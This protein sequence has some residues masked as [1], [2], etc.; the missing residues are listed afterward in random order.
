MNTLIILNLFWDILKIKL[1]NLIK[2]NNESA[3]KKNSYIY[4]AVKLKSLN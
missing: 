3:N 1:S 2:I 4:R